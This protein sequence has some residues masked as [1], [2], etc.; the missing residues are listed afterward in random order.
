MYRNY[1]K[2]YQWAGDLIGTNMLPTHIIMGKKPTA[3]NTTNPTK[4]NY[5]LS[6]TLPKDNWTYQQ[7]TTIPKQSTTVPNYPVKQDNTTVV[8]SNVNTK[9]VESV[10]Q[11]V[12]NTGPQTAYTS[13]N[14]AGK[15]ENFI[16][17]KQQNQSTI[18]P[19]VNKPWYNTAIVETKGTGIASFVSNLLT[20]ANIVGLGS[21]GKQ[22]LKYGIKKVGQFANKKMLDYGKNAF[23]PNLS[24]IGENLLENKSSLINSQTI[25]LQRNVA[26]KV[27]VAKLP[28]DDVDLGNGLVLRNNPSRTTDQTKILGKN[29]ALKEVLDKETGEYIKLSSWADENGKLFYKMS[30]NMPSSRLKAGKAYLELEKH[31]PVGATLMDDTSLS[32]DSFLNTVKQT[33]NPKFKTI[34]HNEFPMNNS[35]KT[36]SGLKN[37]YTGQNLAFATKEEAEQNLTKINELLQKHNLPSAKINYQT[38]YID[39]GDE[40]TYYG[41][42]IPQIGLEKLYQLGILLTALGSSQ[43]GKTNQQVRK[44]GGKVKYQP[45]GKKDYTH[46]VLPN[47]VPFV[48]APYEEQQ[49]YI[50]SKQQENIQN[51][52]N[53]KLQTKQDNTRVVIPSKKVENITK[54]KIIKVEDKK[55]L[56]PTEYA[57]KYYTAPE[58]KIYS[59]PT[60]PSKTSKLWNAI[61]HPITTFSNAVNPTLSARVNNPLSFTEFTLPTPSNIYHWIADPI[62]IATSGNTYTDI[63]KLGESVYQGNFLKT[64]ESRN[65]TLNSAMN[66]FATLPMLKLVNSAGKL[67]KKSP[68][69]VANR[70]MV[71]VAEPTQTGAP[72][73]VTKLRKELNENGILSQQRTPKSTFK[74]KVRIGV[75]PY[76]YNIPE[77]FWSIFSLYKDVKNPKYRTEKQID[78]MVKKELQKYKEHPKFKND[79]KTQRLAEEQIRADISR[80]YSKESSLKKAVIERYKKRFKKTA[81]KTDTYYNTISVAPFKNRYATWDMYLGYPQKR[82]PLYDISELTTSR[83]N[84]IYTIKPE[85][86]NVESIKVHL[87]DNISKIKD[88]PKGDPHRGIYKIGDNKYMISAKDHGHFG[89]MG[90]FNWIVDTLP[91]GNYRLIA[92][93]IWDLQPF[94]R[95]PG[96]KLFTGT[97]LDDMIKKFTDVEVGKALGIG[98]PLNVKVG[99]IVDKDTRE[100]IKTFRLGGSIT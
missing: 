3:V 40:L 46:D 29:M 60:Q 12:F 15:P 93:D 70:P 71:Y 33:K 97:K 50:L 76:G 96:N 57:S 31:I 24:N 84:I 58:E 1:I 74:N 9:A 8:R 65:A 14:F 83:D 47:G 27:K 30:A 34:V 51:I 19:H 66:M 26:P 68:I 54:A 32:Y 5:I 28:F 98:K 25:N 91:D 85:Y 4:S 16:L 17:L 56:T 80:Q 53:S 45:G 48:V 7:P 20:A 87:L 95:Y 39:D 81:I 79:P 37:E 38:Q 77:K 61:N 35:S 64:N 41:I 43:Q 99:F 6:P 11:N 13:V 75:D 82:H 63:A 10:K 22:G 89:T 88:Y 67:F 62:K 73:L 2:K 90:G 55:K 21:I 59:A 49:K 18:V 36:V 52:I 23:T 44:H 86:F 78:K 92:D 94:K 42:T 69:S 72:D 100:I